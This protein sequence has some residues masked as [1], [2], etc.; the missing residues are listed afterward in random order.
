MTYIG[1][2]EPI[3]KDWKI[4][5]Y[6]HYVQSVRVSIWGSRDLLCSCGITQRNG[7]RYTMAHAHYLQEMEARRW[8]KQ[9]EERYS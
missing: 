5:A 6:D 7:N 8:L 3:P 4:N 2:K 9:L 1:V